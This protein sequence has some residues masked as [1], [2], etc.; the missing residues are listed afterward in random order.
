[1]SR[2]RRKKKSDKI[3]PQKSGGIA[4][5]MSLFFL[6][7]LSVNNVYMLPNLWDEEGLQRA[8][9]F[10]AGFVVGGWFAAVFIKG[11]NSVLIHEV[12]HAIISGLAGNKWKRM[13]V[14]GDSGYFK[15]AYSKSTAEYNAFIALAPYWLPLFTVPA[16]LIALP[17]WYG[18]H[19]LVVVIVGIG[20]GADCIL[21]FRDVSR[22][23]TDITHITGG[24][25]VG[26]SYIVVIN[27][28]IATILLAW[29][30]QKVPGL[31]TLVWGL[32]TF[33]MHIVSYYQAKYL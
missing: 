11:K 9:R 24:Y 19:S 10:F 29:V 27:I 5:F 28:A 23:Q 18:S 7:L 30:M 26:L 14:K 1:M 16:L 13:K 31:M 33:C 21:N 15:Y 25:N 32:W 6:T 8:M 3:T 2:K 20:Y 17:I 22:V 4:F 12:K